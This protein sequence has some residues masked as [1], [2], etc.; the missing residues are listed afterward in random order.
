MVALDH[1]K[2]LIIEDDLSESIDL[3]QKLE[4]IGITSIDSSS[5]FDESVEKIKESHYDLAFVDIMLDKDDTSEVLAELLS[6]KNIP[7][8]ITT[9]HTDL[10]MFYSLKKYRPLAYF[11]K[12][13]DSLELRFRLE[14]FN[15]SHSDSKQDFFFYKDGSEFIRI[16][17]ADIIYLEVEGNYVMISTSNEKYMVRSSLKSLL[18]KI[19]SSTFVQIH[20]K[21]AIRID[22]VKSYNS[23]TKKAVLGDLTFPVGRKFQSKL[24]KQL[25]SI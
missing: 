4:H 5:S 7:F 8:I 10:S 9:N 23:H 17:K 1:L 11:Q 21:W 14:D 16:E 15:E 24:A 13:I 22:L 12:P 19:D 6:H 2:A 25:A 3:Q 18:E 20:R